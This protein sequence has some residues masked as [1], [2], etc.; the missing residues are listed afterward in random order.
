MSGIILVPHINLRAIP[1]GGHY[2]RSTDPAVPLA[3]C[4]IHNHAFGLQN[5]CSRAAKRSGETEKDLQMTGGR[6]WIRTTD[7]FLIRQ[8]EW[9]AHLS[10]GKPIVS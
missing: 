3:F 8:A 1:I 6:T 7:L 10:P 2:H 5:G 9:P 4:A